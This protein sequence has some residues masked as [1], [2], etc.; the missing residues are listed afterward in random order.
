MSEAENGL[1]TFSWL[2][3]T[4]AIFLLR[5]FYTKEELTLLFYPILA[6]DLSFKDFIIGNCAKVNNVNELI[7]LFQTWENVIFTVNLS[8][9]SEQLPNNGC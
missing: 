1:R 8:R 6:T 3:T 9:Y 7:S 2:V 4:R 5:C